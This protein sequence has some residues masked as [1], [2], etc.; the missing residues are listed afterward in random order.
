MK[1]INQLE[2]TERK[3][4]L[5]ENYIDMDSS[6]PNWDEAKVFQIE[7]LV[8]K[9]INFDA[10]YQRDKVWTLKEKQNF[11]HSLMTG[12]RVAPLTFSKG[13]GTGFTYIC[14]DGKQRCTTLIDFY[15]SLF[16]I[17]LLI[18][19]GTVHPLRYKD[20]KKRGE[21]GDEKCEEFIT[22][23]LETQITVNL[24]KKLD[25]FQQIEL[26]KRINTHNP[27]HSAEKILCERYIVRTFCNFLWNEIM[28]PMH[29][30][31]KD[32]NNLRLNMAKY[33]LQVL[34]MTAGDSL[35]SKFSPKECTQTALE[36]VTKKMQRNMIEY[37]WDVSTEF[38]LEVLKKE[39]K[40]VLSTVKIIKQA[41]TWAHYMLEEGK[42]I[43]QNRNDSLDLINV[44]CDLIQQGVM[45]HALNDSK[46]S[47]IVKAYRNF[48][49][50]KTENRLVDTQSVTY[51]RLRHDKL[52]DLIREQN[53]DLGIKHRSP[54]RVDQAKA[55]AE[56]DGICPISKKPLTDE[57]EMDHFGN[58]GAATTSSSKVRVVNKSA[59][60]SKET[61]DR[62]K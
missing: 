28:H 19:D 42:L 8:G 54:T 25:I 34:Y 2:I 18:G 10:K 15:K 49:K 37:G 20:I 31:L 35:I 60:R 52:I 5:Y 4:M 16:D 41:C 24:Y 38:T 36:D 57:I 39:N 11:I 13:T 1:C 14:S 53:V 55:W 9:K 30:H 32:K 27:F 62:K 3:L 17:N 59:N 6:G 7:L 47:D 48:L 50:W 12:Y 58:N 21:D 56:S 40:K 45:T 51:L 22:K 61:L 46:K 33:A 29:K 23:F 26:F 43:R 44:Y